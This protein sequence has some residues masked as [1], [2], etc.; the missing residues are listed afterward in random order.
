MKIVR[1][2]YRWFE[3]KLISSFRKKKRKKPI[4]LQKKKIHIY[5]LYQIIIKLQ[6]KL[7]QLY[8]I[9]SKVELYINPQEAFFQCIDN[10]ACVI[11]DSLI[12]L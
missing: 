2:M 3:T 10:A 9:I 12:F 5:P 7:Y 1:K 8:Q 6:K 11:K 4:K